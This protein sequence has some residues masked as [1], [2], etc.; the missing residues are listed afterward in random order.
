MKN[1]KNGRFYETNLERQVWYKD[2]IIHREHEPAIVY[3]DGTKMWVKNA[4]IHREGGPA[5]IYHFGRKEWFLKGTRHREDGP[6]IESG[7]K[8]VYYLHG[9]EYTKDKWWE[10]LSDQAKLKVIFNAGLFNHE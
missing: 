8:K 5:V 2:G 7:E 1:E 6:A 3:D 4:L 9:I 10:N